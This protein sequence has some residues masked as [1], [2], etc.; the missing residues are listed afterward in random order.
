MSYRNKCSKCREIKPL[1][2]FKR[3]SD[4]ASGYRSVCRDCDNTTQNARRDQ[5]R[6]R[7]RIR[8]RERVAYYKNILGGQCVKCGYSKAQCSLEFHHVNSD[9]KEAGIAGLISGSKTYCLGLP[10]CLCHCLKLYKDKSLCHPRFR[11]LT[12]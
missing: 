6:D 2:Q 11:H 4:V 10:V 7:V 3:R 12:T 8:R 5:N 9:E 1:S